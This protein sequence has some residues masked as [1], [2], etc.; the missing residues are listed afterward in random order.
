MKTIPFEGELTED[1]Q[2]NIKEWIAALRSGQYDQGREKLFNGY[3]SYCCLGVACEI[4]QIPKNANGG[5]IF[6]SCSYSELP[7]SQWFLDKY[8]FAFDRNVVVDHLNK[9]T[10]FHL[11]DKGYS[12]KVISDVIEA[13]FIDRVEISFPTIHT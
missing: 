12:F 11:N 7:S 5:F 3:N 10:L 6:G 13:C 4:N 9:W 2:N 1:Q 8:G